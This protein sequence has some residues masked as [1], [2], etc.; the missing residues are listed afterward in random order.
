MY[1]TTQ[2]VC[3]VPSE[4]GIRSSE[5]GA[6]DENSSCELL[7]GLRELRTSSSGR[8]ADA[9]TAET[10]LQ[11]LDLPYF[12]L[13]VGVEGDINLLRSNSVYSHVCTHFSL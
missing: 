13:T 9:L 12:Q 3:L 10:S 1:V 4:E 2:C 8:A 5:P 7:C 6:V 11:P